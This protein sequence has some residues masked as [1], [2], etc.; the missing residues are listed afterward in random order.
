[1]K[2]EIT[3]DHK[4]SDKE[5]MEANFALFT[6]IHSNFNNHKPR[7]IREVIYFMTLGL[8]NSNEREQIRLRQI[9]AYRSGTPP[10]SIKGFT[11]FVSGKSIEEAIQGKKYS[12]QHPEIPYAD[13]RI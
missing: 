2:F 10:A 12:H 7:S 11:K 9:A 4:Q 8:T 13:I 3:G 5:F 6:R 1:M